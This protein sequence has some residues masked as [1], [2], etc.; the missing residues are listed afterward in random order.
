[1][2]L[3]LFGSGGPPAI[4]ALEA[5]AV[6]HDVAAVVV[7]SAPGSRSPR[8]W[9]RLLARRRATR[10]LRNAVRARRIRLVSLRPGGSAD[11]AA[12]L[13]ALHPDLLCVASFP[14]LL[15]P[16]LLACARRGAIGLHPGLLPRHRGPAPLF[17]TYFHDDRE[18]GATVHWL[19]SGADTGR[20]IDQFRLPLSRG[21]T[22]EDL[23]L[24]ISRRGGALLG[25]AVDAIAAGHDQS[26][27]QDPASA[28]WEPSPRPG[29]VAVDAATWPSE[30]VWHVLRGLGG[31]FS[32]LLRR[33]DGAVVLHGRATALRPRPA[34]RTAGDIEPKGP[35]FTVHCQD[36]SVDVA[37]PGLL[38]ALRHRLG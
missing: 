6:R 32:T 5:L 30:R 37:G 25:A 1:V 16:A 29:S 35:G 28:T 10:R 33:P 19:E 36:G 4:A 17:W 21:R 12:R 3:V 27:P 18:A 15:S 9:A 34:N 11:V 31:R 7:P 24:E 26:E 38:A 22:A 13:R 2:R 14:W 20:I 8:G 23:Y